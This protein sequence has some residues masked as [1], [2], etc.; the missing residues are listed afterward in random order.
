M[1]SAGSSWR[2]A[3]P[4]A[5]AGAAAEEAAAAPPSLTQVTW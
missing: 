3:S 2:T 4:S 5:A 1:G